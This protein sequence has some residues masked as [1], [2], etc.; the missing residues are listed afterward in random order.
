MTPSARLSAAIDLFAGIADLR[1]PTAEALRDWG[2]KN[3]YAGA[4]D[5]T[6]IA[7][8]VYDALRTRA[9][10]AWIMGA[11]TPRT[12]VLGAMSRAR[13]MGVQEIA[14]LCSGEKYA[15]EP[16]SDDERARLAAP[17]LVGA[18][19]HVAGD[20]P[21]W[22][23]PHFS[24]AFG[25]DAVAEGRALAQRAPVDL[26]VN[27][28]KCSR[29]KAMEELSHLGPQ[30]TRFAPQGLR[31]VIGA[32]G[33]G[34]ALQAEPAYVKGLVEVQDESSQLV[35]ALSLAAPGEQVLD[36]CAGG[37]GK[38]LALAAAMDNRGQIFATDSEGRRL[39]PI[40]ER[41]ERAGARNVQ[42]RA[43]KGQTDILKDLE[44]RCDL[45]L[46]DAPCTGVGAW[47]RNPDAKWRMRPGALEQRMKD[48]D[49]ALS[50]AARYVKSGG[51]LVYV[52][53]SLLAEENEDRVAAFLGA[54]A[55]FASLDMGEVA[56]KAGLGALRDVA[57]DGKCGLT[58][59]PS[60][61]GADGFFVCAMTRR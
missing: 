43:P 48:Q 47:R 12:I 27:T 51:R 30:P 23:A 14:A 9:S 56:E 16:L 60:R 59:G 37:G 28:L 24:R 20:F 39:M 38:T 44:G 17:S 8:I 35:A 32:D 2:R 22:L 5:R 31:I 7:S 13:N 40:F 57:V 52:T 54:H 49:A 55:D 10:S 42:V 3:R 11:D 26:R 45:V 21:E 25:A 50:R 18:P 41:L 19:D 34:P 29:E 1:I 4:K 36:L 15:P 46:V 58:L 33:R 6:A 61:I 53:C